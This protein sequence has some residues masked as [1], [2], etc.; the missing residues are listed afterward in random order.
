MHTR[1]P[2]SYQRHAKGHVSS[3]RH[4]VCL[5]TRQILVQQFA[6]NLRKELIYRSRSKPIMIALW[7]V[8][9]AWE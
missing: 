3:N 4:F 2:V 8:C 1:S 6:D 9:V 5:C 7:W